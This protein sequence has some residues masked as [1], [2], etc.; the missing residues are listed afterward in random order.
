MLEETPMPAAERHAAVLHLV[1]S[2]LSLVPTVNRAIETILCSSPRPSATET[3]WRSYGIITTPNM[4]IETDPFWYGWLEEQ[5]D[6]FAPDP[7]IAHPDSAVR[8]DTAS[9]AQLEQL[10]ELLQDLKPR[11]YIYNELNPQP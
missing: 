1:H 9:E 4:T 6:H 3:L 8:L 2:S 5:T 10:L 7:G 11:T